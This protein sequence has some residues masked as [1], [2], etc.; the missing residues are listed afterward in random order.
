MDNPVP[1]PEFS[2]PV[3]SERIGREPKSRHLEANAIERGKLAERLG[4]LA[5]SRLVADVEFRRRGGGR[6]ELRGSFEADLVQNC[7]VTLA[8]V[9]ASVGES[10]EMSFIEVD[11]EAEPEARET[12]ISLEGSEPPEP[13][14]GGAID[15]GEAVTQQLAVAIDPYPRAPEAVPGWSDDPADEAEARPHPFADLAKLRKT[16]EIP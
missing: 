15:L 3:R 9:P 11:P 16:G 7:V 5:L 10:F 2:R 8:P 6:I 12:I 4:L 1:T 14:E 13:V